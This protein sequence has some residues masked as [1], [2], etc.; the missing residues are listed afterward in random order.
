[1][2]AFRTA[3][4]TDAIGNTTVYAA[5]DE[6]TRLAILLDFAGFDIITREHNTHR[7][8]DAL[9]FNLNTRRAFEPILEVI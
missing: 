8:M 3:T 9:L 6:I 5:R 7:P 1:M 4:R 2:T